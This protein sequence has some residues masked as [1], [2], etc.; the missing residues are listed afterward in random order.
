MENDISP[1]TKV[2]SDE[3]LLLVSASENKVKQVNFVY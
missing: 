2:A 3:A 1:Q